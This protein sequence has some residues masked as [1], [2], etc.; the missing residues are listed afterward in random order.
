MRPGP[1]SLRRTRL[2]RR[3][4]SRPGSLPQR[5]FADDY[6]PRHAAQRRHRH[7]RRRS[8]RRRAVHRRAPHGGAVGRRLG[9]DRRDGA[10]A[11]RLGRGVY[12]RN[13]RRRGRLG[14][15]RRPPDVQHAGCGVEREPD[16]DDDFRKL[17]GRLAREILSHPP[18]RVRAA[19]QLDGPAAGRTAALGGRL[20]PVPAHRHARRADFPR[21]RL[22]REKPVSGLGVFPVALHERR[23]H[24][25]RHHG[26]GQPDGLFGPPAG[27][28]DRYGR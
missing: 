6:D 16:A 10:P 1:E 25:A 24:L 12:A 8:P 14:R 15:E 11:R 13:P 26:G 3:K 27:P 7:V 2:R 9:A 21:S 5:A 4:N 22:R 17:D 19:E 18:R 20:P 28:G 23:L